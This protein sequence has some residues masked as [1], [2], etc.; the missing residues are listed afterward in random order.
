MYPKRS[1]TL[2]K[3]EGRKHTVPTHPSAVMVLALGIFKKHVGKGGRNTAW[4]VRKAKWQLAHGLEARDSGGKAGKFRKIQGGRW[5][6]VVWVRGD[7]FHGEGHSLSLSLSRDAVLNGGPVYGH[8]ALAH[9]AIKAR[10]EWRAERPSAISQGMKHW[11]HYPVVNPTPWAILRPPRAVDKIQPRNFAGSRGRWIHGIDGNRA[12]IYIRGGWRDRGEWTNER[13]T[14]ERERK[15]E[16]KKNRALLWE[17][18]NKG[19]IERQRGGKKCLCARTGL[20][21]ELQ[22]LDLQGSDW[23][24]KIH[25]PMEKNFVCSE[26]RSNLFFL[27]LLLSNIG[28]RLWG[29][30]WERSVLE[31]IGV[32]W[33][34]SWKCFII[35]RPRSTSRRKGGFSW[36]IHRSVRRLDER[37][38][39]EGEQRFRT[40]A[41]LPTTFV[42]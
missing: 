31:A 19:V 35:Y 8:C 10:I 22:G 6:G 14:S 12:G 25:A 38:N 40:R 37:R 27:R 5:R 15:E 23:W 13:M 30:G 36:N 29:R 18:V 11:L 17:S 1:T 2:K 7:G 39:T 4:K 41:A 20:E 26:D 34:G 42:E 3:K 33:P 24:L 21:E 28:S 16:K 32:G 9:G